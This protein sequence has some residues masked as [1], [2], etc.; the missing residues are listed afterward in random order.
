MSRRFVLGKSN[1]AELS[2][3]RWRIKKSLLFWA[4]SSTREISRT[5]VP[6]DIGWLSRTRQCRMELSSLSTIGLPVPRLILRAEKSSVQLGRWEEMTRP[7][8]DQT[9]RGTSR[10]ARRRQGR[11]PLP[12]CVSL[13]YYPQAFRAHD[14]SLGQGPCALRGRLEASRSCSMQRGVTSLCTERLQSNKSYTK[15]TRKLTLH[16]LL[17]YDRSEK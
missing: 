11:A 2:D 9:S 3:C 15:I 12:Q 14:V 4:T 6:D 5:S 17:A 10:C 8:D 7:T 16:S 13:H 1:S